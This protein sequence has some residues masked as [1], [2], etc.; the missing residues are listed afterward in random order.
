MPGNFDGLELHID[1]KKYGLTYY[2]IFPHRGYASIGCI[3]SPQ[4]NPAHEM[5][6]RFNRWAEEKGIDLAKQREGL[7]QYTSVILVLS[8]AF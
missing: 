4:I 3:F 8:T 2:W 7:T 6:E 1:L 5:N